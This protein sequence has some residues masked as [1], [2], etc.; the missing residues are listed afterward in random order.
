MTPGENGTL[1]GPKKPGGSVEVKGDEGTVTRPIDP[2][3]PDQG[4]ENIKVP[5]GSIV[6]PDGTIKLPTER[7]SS[8]RISSRRGHSEGL[9][10][11]DL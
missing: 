6:Y 4:K 3:K 2:A 11:R 10:D 5:E 9:C 1:D 7:S 8:R